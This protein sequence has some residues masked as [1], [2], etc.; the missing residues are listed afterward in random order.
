M[1]YLRQHLSV[2]DIAVGGGG[3]GDFFSC[4]CCLGDDDVDCFGDD[5]GDSDGGVV[6]FSYSHLGW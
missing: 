5:S 4:W 3:G 6:C 1:C 2:V